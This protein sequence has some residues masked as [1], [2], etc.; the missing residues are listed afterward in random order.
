MSALLTIQNIINNKNIFDGDLKYCFM[1]KNKVPYTVGNYK[2][3]PNVIEDFVELEKMLDNNRIE[4]YVGV[5][6]S[7]QANEI[8]AIDVDKCFSNKFDISSAD[9]RALEII[10]IFK[11][12]AYIEFSFSGNGLRVLFKSDI[13]ENYADTYYIK[14]SKNGIEYYQ[15]SNSYRYVSITGK[16]IINNFVLNYVDKSLLLFFLD[17]YMTRPKLEK[18]CN[19]GQILDTSVD[20]EQLLIHHYRSNFQFQDVWFS[21]APGAGKDESEKDFYLLSYIYTNITQNKD[22]IKE[23]FEMSPFFKSKDSNHKYKWSYNN[24]RYFNYIYNR[25]SS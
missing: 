24:Y 3:K 6:L 1:D 9:S 10:E 19:V 11:D 4:D 25:L 20:Y 23:L 18:K 14:N 8:C 5:G 15:P 12:I 2:A 16:F 22:K 7:I 17:N 13:I 21:K